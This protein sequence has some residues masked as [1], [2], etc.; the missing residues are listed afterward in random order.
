MWFSMWLLLLLLLLL[1]QVLFGNS[2]GPLLP[3]LL[4]LLRASGGGNHGV[5]GR[6]IPWLISLS[7][8]LQ[9][10]TLLVAVAASAV[11]AA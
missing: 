5:I 3:L 2:C 7:F 6:E 10:L 9:T 4:P 1:L 8:K 11:M